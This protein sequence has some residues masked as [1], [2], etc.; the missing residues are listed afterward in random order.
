MA[1]GV[2]RRAAIRQRAAY[3]AFAGLLLIVL[4]VLN[5]IANP[6][7]FEPSQIL[8]TV[9]IAAPLV[10][11]AMAVTPAVLVGGGGID[12]SVG[13]LMSVVGAIVVV[14]VVG[15]L[16]VTTPLVVIPV[17]LGVGIA[18]GVFTGLL[19][20]VLRLQPM[21]ATLGTYL[22]YG[23]L[24][25]V[26]APQPM[27]S[28]PSWLG[29]MAQDGSIPTLVI[30]IGA[31]W[32]FTRTPLYDALMAT[33]GDDRAAYA[34]GVPVTVVRLM[35]YTMSGL[36][37]AIGGLSLAAL[38]ASADPNAGAEYTLLGIA[39]VALG[40]VS[41]AGGR[42]GMFGAVIGALDVFLIQNILTYYNIS[43]FVEQVFYG[44]VLVAA[45]CVNRIVNV[46]MS[47]AR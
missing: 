1:P 32:F 31:W 2:T 20:A 16:H 15:Q 14:E 44:T 45:V 9:G 23:G 25:L 36:L 35:A 30:V 4:L 42:G 37:A 3:V 43:S 7:A 19:V 10:L 5:A 34:A 13:P 26:I 17:A 12:L 33:G 28:V 46:R 22:A 27:G 11:A 38:L 29:A 47:P 18:S 8:I 21:V 40:G 24:A 6:V 41:L 39:A